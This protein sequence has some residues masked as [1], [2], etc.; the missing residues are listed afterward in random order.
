M[1]IWKSIKGFEGLYEVS[2]Q[3]R[4]KVLQRTA[5]GRL[6]NIQTFKERILSPINQSNGYLKVNLV[7]DGIQKTCL[8]HR[9]VASAFIEGDN[10]LTVNHINGIKTDNRV[11]N[12][13]WLSLSENHK[14]AFRIGLKCMK[15]EKSNGNKLL[16]HQVIEIK[17]LLNQGITHQK[18]ADL[19]N[20]RRQTVTDINLKRRWS[21]I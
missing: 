7:K 17:K 13:E 1:E 10:S 14:H 6:N 19:Y 9:I 8:I 20:V 2:N 21:H 12:L 4:V 5:R 18:I 16:E 3:G 15:G 11:E